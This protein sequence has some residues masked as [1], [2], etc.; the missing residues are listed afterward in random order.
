[1]KDIY[2]YVCVC[3]LSVIHAR[4]KELWNKHD[5]NYQRLYSP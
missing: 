1:M 4:Q 2:I 3:V 5:V